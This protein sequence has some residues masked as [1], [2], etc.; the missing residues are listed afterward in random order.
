M[1]SW[2]WLVVYGVAILI[3]HVVSALLGVLYGLCGWQNLERDTKPAR[4]TP[5]P[6]PPSDAPLVSVIVPARDEE[7]NIGPC[8][9]AILAQDEPRFE[10]VVLD[11]GSS[12]ATRARAIEAAGGDP[13]VR[14]E[15]GEPRGE[16]W[17][18]KT[19]ALHCAQKHA[20]SPLLLFVDA[21][22]RLA[23]A[24]LRLAVS[25]LERERLDMLSLMGHLAVESFWEG[26]VQPI[27]GY[28]IVAFFPLDRVNSARSRITMCNG[29]LILIRRS[30]YDAIGGHVPLKDAILEDVELART[31]KLEHGRPYRLLLAPHAFTC[32]MYATLGEI[33]HGW[34]KNFYA[35][36]RTSTLR[37]LLA[38]GLLV[39]FSFSPL[40][41]AAG[42]L[43]AALAGA[44][45]PPLALWLLL[46][47]GLSVLALRAWVSWLFGFPLRHTLTH[48]LGVLVV[49]A[50]FLA[51][52]WKGL[53]GRSVVW[54]GRRYV[55]AKRG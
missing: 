36:M 1:S 10:L 30:T 18:G 14:I 5:P 3:Y 47:A 52:T 9:R 31:V 11:D 45:V 38:I 49:A 46:S 29:Q 13:R 21:D 25:R 22:V 19:W 7:A 50:I 43:A 53:T 37:S 28:V 41:V 34:G 4:P 39:F 55:V 20:R 17:F 35:A 8:I 33:W 40:A 6:P 44:A 2:D 15:A 54:K 16:G 12:D 24:C 48:P 51:S 42:I 32:R 23:P 27:L 26:V